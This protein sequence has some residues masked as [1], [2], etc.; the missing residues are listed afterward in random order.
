MEQT[1]RVM[2]YSTE[3]SRPTIPAPTWAIVVSP[4]AGGVGDF[5][6]GGSKVV[7]DGLDGG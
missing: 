2:H 1:I 3:P 4:L 6:Q 7:G 5:V